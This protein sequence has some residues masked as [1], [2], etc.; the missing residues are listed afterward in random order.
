MAAR[1]RVSDPRFDR[2][3][4]GSL[5]EARERPSG[6]HV[7]VALLLVATLFVCHGL[8]GASHLLV[9]EEVPDHP[10]AAET[11]S[12]TH[13]AA[14]HA[15]GQDGPPAGGAEYF[16]V[17]LAL[18]GAGLLAALYGPGRALLP[19]PAWRAISATRALPYRPLRGGLSP[20]LLQVFRL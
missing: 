14:G 15:A 18:A 13:H 4:L 12:G 8:F 17:L 6:R 2:A 20:P 19:A 1:I 11:F 3:I 16:A 9:H 5:G 10:M 7:F